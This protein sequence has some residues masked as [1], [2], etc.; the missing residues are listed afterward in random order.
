MNFPEKVTFRFIDKG[1]KKPIENIAVIIIL[2]AKRKNDYE[3]GPKFS[4]K[5]GYI[6]FSKEECIRGIKLSQ[7]LFIMDYFSSLEDCFPKILLKTLN[8]KNIDFIIEHFDEYKVFWDRDPFCTVDFIDRLKKA[9][10]FTYE[11]VSIE[12]K[13]DFLLKN[14]NIIEIELVKEKGS[15]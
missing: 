8:T 15:E 2:Y 12:F 6:Y 3:I 11:T 7:E 4:D 14:N 9:N 5:N 10:N 13:E 1:T